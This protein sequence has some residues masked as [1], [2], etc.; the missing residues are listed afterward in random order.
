MLKSLKTKFLPRIVFSSVLPAAF[1][2]PCEH[3]ERSS[4][5]DHRMHQSIH[6]GLVAQ[7]RNGQPS[8]IKTNAYR[9]FNLAIKRMIDLAGALI[10]LAALGPMLIMVAAIIR[11]SDGGPIFFRQKRVGKD[12]ALFDIVK[13]RTMRIEA[14][15]LS[16]VQQT[17]A[18][19]ERMTRMGA[20]LRRTSIDE[21]P[22][23]MNIVLGH[24]SLV[25]P[26]PHVP[27][28]LACGRLYEELVPY[29]DHRHSMLPGLTGWAQ[30]N[31]LRGATDSTDA[32][33]GRV[34]HDIAYIQNFSFWLDIRI[35]FRT[36]CR[37]FLTGNAQ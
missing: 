29:Y 18:G 17:V 11:I 3:E 25:G 30:T 12:G 6:S 32:A 5:T 33:I 19:D 15:D 37:E 8:E 20:F 4:T 1:A 31:G 36:V 14:C 10:A 21:L 2:A 7:W 27:G 35:I 34:E 24:M 9:R 26:R 13:F 28:M 23:L 16:G 22:Q